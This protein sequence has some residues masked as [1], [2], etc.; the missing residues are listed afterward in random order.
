LYNVIATECPIQSIE[1]PNISS[2]NPKIGKE[3]L[4]YL[5]DGLKY[6]TTLTSTEI[7]ITLAY[8]TLVLNCVDINIGPKGCITL[9]ESLNINRTL[10]VLDISSNAIKDEGY[11][12]LWQVLKES[13]SITE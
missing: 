3:G 4:E 11:I 5:C 10:T 8:T 2:E 6:N 1:E 13:R 12:K 9:A 7:I